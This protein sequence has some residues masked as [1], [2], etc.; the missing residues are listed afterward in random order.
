M[1]VLLPEAVKRGSDGRNT[2]VVQRAVFIAIL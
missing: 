1:E 2:Y